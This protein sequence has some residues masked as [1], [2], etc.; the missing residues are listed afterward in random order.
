M[1][2]HKFLSAIYLFTILIISPNA[3][4]AI[5][6]DPTG[7]D[8]PMLSRY[9]GSQ[10]TGYTM[11]QFDEAMLPVSPVLKGD[12]NGALDKTLALEG[13]R[14]RLLYI[15]PR[16]RSALEVMRNYE[17]ALTEAG[18]KTLFSCAREKCGEDFNSVGR[19]VY[20]Q[21]SRNQIMDRQLNE[22]A[23]S[24]NIEDPRMLTAVLERPSGSVYFFIFTAHQDN[25]SENEANNRVATYVEVV[26]VKAM[27][28]G[29]VKVDANAMKKALGREGK[30]ALHG[31]YF[32][33]NSAD[34][35]PDSQPQLDEMVKLLQAHSSLKVYIVG[36]TDNQGTLEYNLDLSHN[37]AA[38][39]VKALNVQGI[40]ANRMIARGVA[41]LAPIASN[42]DDA[43]RTKNRRVELVEQ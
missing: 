30:I 29:M 39:V 36:H 20:F 41:N 5:K 6:E 43:G 15:A 7:K 19:A 2:C 32:D 22:Y 40:A 26:E 37:R 28:F 13:K 3:S 17:S 11:S 10:L 16:D 4:S 18:A 14:T 38:A 35:K 12:G 31:I 27:Q 24:M 9:A 1:T 25:A 23:F 34:I 33:T 42:T 21:N 8:H